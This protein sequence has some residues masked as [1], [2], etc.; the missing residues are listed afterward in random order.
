VE[1]GLGVEVIRPLYRKGKG[2]SSWRDR[3]VYDFH[4]AD[5]ALKT[6]EALSFSGFKIEVIESGPFGDVVRVSPSN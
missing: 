5:A 4:Y 2:W 6:G 1:H 3:S